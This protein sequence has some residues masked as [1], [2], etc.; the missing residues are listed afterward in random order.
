MS[1]NKQYLKKILITGGAGFLGSKLATKLV[2]E[3]YLVTVIDKQLYSNT[4]LDHLIPYSNFIFIKG[5]VRDKKL[6]RKIL[7]NQDFVIPLALVGAPLVKKIKDWL[8][9]LI[10]LLLNLL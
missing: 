2:F 8:L 1:N 9:K 10:C 5:D 7:K 6:M 4:S 3:N